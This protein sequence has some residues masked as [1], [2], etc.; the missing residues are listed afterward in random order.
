MQHK[1]FIYLKIASS[2]KLT[3]LFGKIYVVKANEILFFSEN[4]TNYKCKNQNI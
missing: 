4:K 3:L 1:S 2:F